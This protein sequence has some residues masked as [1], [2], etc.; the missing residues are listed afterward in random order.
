MLIDNLQGNV[1]RLYSIS[2]I[3]EIENARRL[4]VVRRSDEVGNL[5]RW[6]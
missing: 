3:L 1:P 4:T 5:V 2:I 6:R